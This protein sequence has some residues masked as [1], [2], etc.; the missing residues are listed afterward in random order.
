[1]IFDPYH[2]W[3]SATGFAQFGALE[4][5]LWVPVI[6]QL[7]DT[8]AADFAENVAQ[9]EL[10]W[11]QIPAAYRYPA[12]ALADA[13]F[14]TALVR[15]NFFT[16]L[17]RPASGLA[18]LVQRYEIGL[19]VNGPQSNL[20]ALAMVDCVGALLVPP[21]GYP[22]N[23]RKA[24]TLIAVIDEGLAFAHARFRDRNGNSRVDALWDQEPQ[25]PVS[26]PRVP[27]Q[28][29]YGRE[30]VAAEIDRWA[31]AARLADPTC[32]W[33]DEDA[34]YRAAEFASVAK[35]SAHGA[36]VM[37]IAGGADPSSVSGPGSGTAR[38]IG[39]Q[40]G[41]QRSLDTSGRWLGVQVLNALRY[42]LDRADRLAYARGER[43]GG[44]IVANLSFGNTAGPHDGSSLLE[45]AMD[46]LIRL[47]RRA[48]GTDTL[49][50]VIAAGN[51]YLGRVHAQFTLAPSAIQTLAWRVLPDDATPSFVEIYPADAAAAGTLQVE[52]VAPSGQASGWVRADQ[53]NTAAL[54]ATIVHAKTVADGAR[55]VVLVAVS[56]TRND[57]A[58]QSVV[59][60]AM[61]GLW[62]IRVRTTSRT[63][64]ALIHAWIERDETPL[65]R[66]PRGRQSYFDD[67]AN[68]RFTRLGA[69]SEQDSPAS[70]V[71]R[72]HTLNGIACGAQTVI[73]GGHRE[74]QGEIAEYSAAGPLR[75]SADAIGVTRA[76][77]RTGPDVVAPSDRSRVQHGMLAAGTR[78]GSTVAMNG[79]SVAAP[80]VARALAL[81][82]GRSPATA[83]ALVDRLATGSRRA[84]RDVTR[85]GQGRV[86]KPEE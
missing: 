23:P 81:V 24:R 45:Q 77:A 7:R 69:L 84:G 9:A 53:V 1:M 46:E 62:H 41:A 2:A 6:M 61:A 60:T 82:L 68:E 67:P 38:I 79:T 78:S 22:T 39:V 50:I 40:L 10:P 70:Y 32:A 80:V 20:S 58:N 52:L 66:A 3:A 42:V 14:C 74:A 18:G 76:S 83:R 72:S 85:M 56:P 73:V 19:A 71:R 51:H 86:P 27:T 15:R 25:R 47:R 4:F 33:V 17:K 57:G 64:E 8:T 65:G 28:F 43:V 5:D 36:H 44:A 31:A 75:A 16:E 29:G 26:V 12:H 37:D 54:G 59:P 55:P 30:I 35:R 48:D 34:V 13:T 49:A 63:A 21:L 11:I